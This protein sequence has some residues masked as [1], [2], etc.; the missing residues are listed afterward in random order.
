VE[1]SAHEKAG[2]PSSYT[3]ESA[4]E[5]CAR[6]SEG[7]KSLRTVC[8]ELGIHHT[9][10]LTWA[11]DNPQFADQ[12]A[13]ARVI[14]DDLDFDDIVDEAS[15]PPPTVK[16]FVDAGW[17]AWKKNLIEAKKW[18]LSK[19]RPKKYGDKTTTAL[20]GA[21]DGP[22]KLEVEDVKDKLR[23]LLFRG[24]TPQPTGIDQSGT[25]NTEGD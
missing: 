15:E 1:Q 12:Y 7:G 20:V 9:T 10:V 18:S 13:R 22:V 21:D 8:N 6:L 25:M 16:G 5:I 4:D 17:V 14:A 24:S 2:R 19:R 23:A 11:R 3:Q